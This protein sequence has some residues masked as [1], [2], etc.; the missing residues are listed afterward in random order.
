MRLATV[1]TLGLLLL[2]CDQTW[3]NPY[4]QDPPDSNTLYS[5]FSLRP[6][7]L[8]PAKS[9]SEDE[10]IFIGQIYEPP[11]QYNYLK[12]PYEL[13]PLTATKMPD[14][15]YDPVTDTTTYTINIKPGIFFQQHPALTIHNYGTSKFHNLG[16]ERVKK[17]KVLDDFKSKGTR[18]LEAADYVYQIKRLADPKVN[19]PIYGVMQKYILGFADFRSEVQKLY[20]RNPQLIGADLRHFDLAGAKTIDKYTYQI[21]IHGQYPQFKYWLAMLFFAPVPWEADKFYYQPGLAENNISLDW[22]PIGTGPFFLSENN[23]D[24]RM[25]LK[26]N[27]LFREEHFPGKPDLKIPMLDR[28]VFSLER[29]SIP[30]WDKFLQGY[31]DASGISEDNFN[32]AIASG[33][34]LQLSEPLR[35]RGVKLRVYER[36][37]VVYWA[38]NMLDPVVGG[39]SEQSRKLRR[40]INLAFDIDEFIT[41]FYNGRG[42]PAA[43]PIPLGILGGKAATEDTYN[44]ELAKKLLAEA[45]YPDGKDPKTDQQLQIFYEAAVSG[46]PSQQAELTWLRKQL[47]KI[48]IDLIIRA[49]DYN[50]FREKIQ[51]GNAQIFMWGWNAD[52]PDPENFLFLLYGPNSQVKFAGENTANYNNPEYNS[53][54]EKFMQVDDQTEKLALINEMIKILDKDVPWIWGFYPQQYSLYNPWYGFVARGSVINN[55]L[56]YISLDPK[57]RAELRKQWNSPTI[58]PVFIVVLVVLVIILPAIYGFIRSEKTTARRKK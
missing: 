25:V 10:Y 23:P 24:R 34:G 53:L 33:G 38:F 4:P 31:F 55:F 42:V 26:R 11:L 56:K 48:G 57:Q 28:V 30:A 14:V 18:E 47:E 7:H 21:T 43:G 50:R 37:S 58:W 3:N 49:T 51:T 16:P 1:I 52:Y 35:E 54:Y 9:Y 41:I 17:Y 19:S 36:L 20:D 46:N 12:R 13:E 45:G 15:K 8:D 39:Y 6:K 40:A 5:A 27:D 32:Y 22:Y 2:G 29:E 44:P